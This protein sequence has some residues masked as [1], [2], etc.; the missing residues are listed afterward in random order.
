MFGSILVAHVVVRVFPSCAYT[1]IVLVVT[2]GGASMRFVFVLVF[3]ACVRISALIFKSSPRTK[4]D[5][6]TIVYQ[7]IVQVGLPWVCLLT[8]CLCR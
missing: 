5:F 7:I 8:L 2:N 4:K 1:F 3:Q 6:H